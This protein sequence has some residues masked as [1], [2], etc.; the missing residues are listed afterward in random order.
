LLENDV[1]PLTSGNS[2]AIMYL[3]WSTIEIDSCGGQAMIKNLVKHGNSWAVVI[4]RPILDLLKIAPESQ[5]ELTTDGKSIRI[6]PVDSDDKKARVRAAR[7]SVNS[8]HSK[9]FRKLAE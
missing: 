3:H 9:A 4:D 7:V 2:K 6:A 1:T 8:K 5:V